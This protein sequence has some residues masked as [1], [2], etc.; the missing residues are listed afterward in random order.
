MQQ[1]SAQVFT[2]FMPTTTLV[3]RKELSFRGFDQLASRCTPIVAPSIPDFIA[4]PETD[5][6]IYAIN[7]NT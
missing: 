2:T 6:E 3:E 1:T 7:Q 4:Q 5:L